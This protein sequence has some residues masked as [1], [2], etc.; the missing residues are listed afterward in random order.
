[1]WN[2]IPRNDSR[3][4]GIPGMWFFSLEFSNSSEAPI[5]YIP[6][7]VVN[8]C[9]ELGRGVRTEGARP[10]YNTYLYKG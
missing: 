7:Q 3:S 6:V 5:Q 4:S 2:G 1:M 8:C 9:P 10:L